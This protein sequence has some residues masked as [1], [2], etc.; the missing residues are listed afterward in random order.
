VL[1]I[2]HHHRFTLYQPPQRFTV[3]Q[4]KQGGRSILSAI[5]SLNAHNERF[6]LVRLRRSAACPVSLAA[7]DGVMNRNLFKEQRRRYLHSFIIAKRRRAVV[8]E[9]EGREEAEKAKALY[10]PLSK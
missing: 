1:R 8:R 6:L 4:A 5:F 9:V 2:K 10:T 7:E 3:I